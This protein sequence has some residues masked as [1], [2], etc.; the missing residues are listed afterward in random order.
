MKTLI[1]P[2]EAEDRILRL[3]EG[4]P[5]EELLLLGAAGRILREDIRADQ[6]FPPF[7]RVMMDGIAVRFSDFQ[8]GDRSFEI[9]GTA[10][11]GKPAKPLPSAPSSAI[12][13]MT[14]AV[15]PVGSDCILP[16][17][18]YDIEN[19][20]AILR[21]VAAPREGVFIHRQGSDHRAGEVLM[22]QGVRIGPVETSV[23]AACGYASLRVTKQARIT[24]IG[25]GDELVGIGEK[26]SPGQIR[27]TNAPTLAASLQLAGHPARDMTHAPD[28]VK[29]LRRLFQKVFSASDVVVMTGG[30]SK[31]R[32]DFVPD[33]LRELG[34]R[35]ILH[36]VSQ[37]P[38]KPMA[39]WEV[40]DGP[41]VFGLPGNPVSALVCLHRYVIP[42]LRQWSGEVTAAPQV[43]KVLG[44]FARPGG[45]TLFLPVADCGDGTAQALPTANS[46]DFAG[47][48]GST[49]FV[50]VDERFA[51]HS[52]AHYFSWIA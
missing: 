17:E 39:V 2:A 6:D 36:G 7:D 52:S 12:E 15:L 29:A 20:R 49:G 24:L 51:T 26:P 8:A 3:R 47:L 50:E 13:V 21:D 34:G 10:A 45:L 43:R 38:G 44:D 5:C 14:G 28:E 32:R 46:G 23:A 35:E 16:V 11:A 37:R 22:K 33:I 1:T 41:V 42:A 25:T 48:L 9:T 27:Q 40:P 19:G 4:F 30:V 31:G 18:W